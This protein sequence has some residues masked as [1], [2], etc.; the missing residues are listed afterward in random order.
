MSHYVVLDSLEPQILLSGLST[1]ISSACP[2]SSITKVLNTVF[3]HSSMCQASSRSLRHLTEN[4]QEACRDYCSQPYETLRRPR[5]T[6]GS[7]M[8]KLLDKGMVFMLDF[9]HPVESKAYTEVFIE[10]TASLV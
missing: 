3:R 9:S 1:E 2:S 4:R 5:I 10:E 7:Y 8:L 6:E